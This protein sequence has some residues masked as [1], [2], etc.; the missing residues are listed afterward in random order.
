MPETEEFHTGTNPGQTI[1]DPRFVGYEIEVEGGSDGRLDAYLREEGIDSYKLH[2]DGSL[3]NGIELVTDPASLDELEKMVKTY[4]KV[5]KKAGYRI[6]QSCGLHTHIDARDIANSAEAITQVFKTV[7]AI[8][9]IIFLLIDEDRRA[10]NF[11]RSIRDSHAFNQIPHTDDLQ[12]VA[13]HWYKLSK[14]RMVANSRFGGRDVNGMRYSGLNLCSVF[15]RGSIEF[16]YHEGSL[17]WRT[18]LH[19]GAF[20][21]AIVN[22]AIHEYDNNVI[23]ALFRTEYSLTKAKEV[24]KLL[25]ISP[26]TTRHL[27]YRLRG[28]NASHLTSYQR[29]GRENPNP[30]PLSSDYASGGGAG[31]SGSLMYRGVPVIHDE[32]EAIAPN[33]M[34]A[35]LN[36]SLVFGGGAGGNINEQAVAAPDTAETPVIPEVTTVSPADIV[37]LSVVKEEVD[38]IFI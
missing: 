16:R 34:M 8:E 1:T 31:F 10:N 24:F 25:K 36:E 27:L 38:S 32:F 4:T 13:A 20:L 30:N 15:Y 3:R 35:G 5:L 26:K 33:D 6:E 19:W 28:E 14:E 12:E 22:Y 9:D 23:T 29:N 21:Q 11:C 17:N 2:D 7:Y 37:P 18:M